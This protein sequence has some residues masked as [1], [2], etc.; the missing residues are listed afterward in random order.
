[1]TTR[2]LIGFDIPI[3]AFVPLRVLKIFL[4]ILFIAS[5]VKSS[6]DNGGDEENPAGISMAV[7]LGWCYLHAAYHN[8]YTDGD[9]IAGGLF[10]TAFG[11]HRLDPDKILWGI[12]LSIVPQVV[13]FVQ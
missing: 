4:L 1:M 6:K 7:V 9:G 13:V 11:E 2:S 5:V 3:F 8:G 12:E 10:V